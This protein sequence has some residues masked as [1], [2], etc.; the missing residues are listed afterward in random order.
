MLAWFGRTRTNVVAAQAEAVIDVRV[1]SMADAVRISESLQA[2]TP[3]SPGTTLE[4]SGGIGRPP[5]ERTPAVAILFRQA[6]SVA[7]DLGR[8]LGEVPPVE[9]RDT[10]PPRLASQH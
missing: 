5:F 4:V 1:S 7:A 10:R 6:R 9:A 8:E 3:Q 2:L